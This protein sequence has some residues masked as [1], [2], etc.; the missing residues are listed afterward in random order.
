M[1][2]TTLLMSQ[3]TFLHCKALLLKGKRISQ[4]F[5]QACVGHRPVH[6]WF[7]GSY[8][9]MS[10]HVSTY[11]GNNKQQCDIDCV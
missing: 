3:V 2:I 5:N 11:K 9:S 4:L 1:V 8:V 10:V 7:L 6:T